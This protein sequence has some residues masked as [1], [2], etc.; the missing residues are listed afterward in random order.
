MTPRE[1]A[2]RDATAYADDDSAADRLP[3][4]RAMRAIVLLAI[5]AWMLLT[6]IA[7]VALLIAKAAGWV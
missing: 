7:A 5:A 6:G 3:W 1:A 4:P 2:A